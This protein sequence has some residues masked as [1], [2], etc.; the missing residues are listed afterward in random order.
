MVLQP[1]SGV[2]VRQRDRHGCC[3]PLCPGDGG[4]GLT[5]LAGSTT[6]LAKAARK[7]SPMRAAPAETGR[8]LIKEGLEL[9]AHGEGSTCR[10]RLKQPSRSPDSESAPPQTTMAPGWY[11]SITCS[12]LLMTREQPAGMRAQAR[13][14]SSCSQLPADAGYCCF[15]FVA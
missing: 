13:W 2:Q 14:E 15:C 11:I 10:D 3:T 12:T 9:E 4:W 8:S 6:A 5:G 7:P 1:M